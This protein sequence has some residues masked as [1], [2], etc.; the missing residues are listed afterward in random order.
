LYFLANNMFSIVCYPPNILPADVT[1]RVS[2][3]AVA[4]SSNIKTV[5]PRSPS[6]LIMPTT[7]TVEDWLW[8]VPAAD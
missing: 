4:W 7:Q 2:R 1:P 5:N 3:W 8:L 6:C